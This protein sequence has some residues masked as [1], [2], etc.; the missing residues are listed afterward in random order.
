MEIKVFKFNW[1]GIKKASQ[2]KC[3]NIVSLVGILSGHKE[4]FS[5]QHYEQ[6]VKINKLEKTSFVLNVEDL[7][8]DKRSTVQDKCLVIFLGAKRNYLDY[9]KDKNSS[10]PIMIIEDILDID[11]LNNNP[12]LSVE[13]DFINFKIY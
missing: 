9:I 6:A 11:K 12:L 13:G 1:E 5:R 8:N 4:N 10:L 7:L 2:G 3:K